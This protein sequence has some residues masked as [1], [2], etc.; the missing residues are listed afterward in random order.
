MEDLNEN[1]SK[2][3]EILYT[4]LEALSWPCNPDTDDIAIGG[5]CIGVRREGFAGEVEISEHG[6]F[7]A[8]I[9]ASAGPTRAT[10]RIQAARDFRSQQYAIESKI[11]WAS[12]GSV[13][14][15][16]GAAFGGAILAWS[17]RLQEATAALAPLVEMEPAAREDGLKQLALWIDAHTEQFVDGLMMAETDRAK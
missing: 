17:G 16:D 6:R 5:G 10:V 7:R 15:E 2:A 11:S 8:T 3:L 12:T 13:S 9:E 1:G 4:L 14:A